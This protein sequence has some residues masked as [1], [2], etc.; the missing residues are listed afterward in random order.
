MDLDSYKY[1]DTISR[2]FNLMDYKISKPEIE[3]AN[4]L[5]SLDQPNV[6]AIRVKNVAE[7]IMNGYF[8][9]KKHMPM[10]KKMLDSL[11]G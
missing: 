7:S 6:S 9:T 4:Y 2:I 5:I 10:I 1:V 11:K 3:S 8:E